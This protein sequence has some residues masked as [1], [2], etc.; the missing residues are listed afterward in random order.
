MPD[1][2]AARLLI[3]AAKRDLQGLE[4]M[5]DAEVFSPP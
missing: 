2:D 3:S 5:L 1:I 4:N